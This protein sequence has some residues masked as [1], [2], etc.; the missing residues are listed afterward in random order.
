MV[1]IVN[2][3]SKGVRVAF[4]DSPRKYRNRIDILTG[5]NGSGKTE[6]LATLATMF[7][8][9]K[10]VAGARVGWQ[11]VNGIDGVVQEFSR[12]EARWAAPR[13]IAQTFSPFSRFPAPVIGEQRSNTDIYSRGSDNR[14]RYRPVGIHKDSRTLGAALSRAVLEQGI[15]RL[16]EQQEQLR[17][18]GEVLV[19]LGYEPDFRL[20]YARKP[21]FK[22]LAAAA[23]TGSLHDAIAQMVSWRPGAAPPRS[24]LAVELRRVGGGAEEFVRVLGEALSIVE[25]EFRGDTEL[26]LYFTLDRHRSSTDFSVLQ[27]LALLRRLNLLRLRAFTLRS[28]KRGPIELSEAS[29]GEQQL[30]CSIFGLVSEL[31]SGALVLI[32]EPELSLHPEWQLMFLP[33]LLSI[34]SPFEECHAI[35]AT[36][37]PL[38]VQQASGLSE[39]IGVVSLSTRGEQSE[40]EWDSL[41][42]TPATE[43]VSVEEALVD[44]FHTPVSNSVYLSNEVF[45]LITQAE[46][47]GAKEWNEASVRLSV[48]ERVYDRETGDAAS[49][50]LLQKARKV[51]SFTDPARQQR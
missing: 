33:R 23:R 42:D 21:E 15:F 46:T 4:G 36:H 13:V 31:E 12:G 17:P 44:V 10:P 19:Q 18:V 25:N 11:K 51:L 28:I 40:E 8:L 24:A 27:S 41:S 1:Q 48:L 29:S 20:H 7:G 43:P 37:S 30:L 45:A 32:D 35:I 16:S 47:G 39:G 3:E 5:P 26:K 38:I 50:Q 34:L 9:D 22:T 2:F 49:R 6:V 14:E